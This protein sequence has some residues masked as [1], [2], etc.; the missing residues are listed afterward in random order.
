MTVLPR[1]DGQVS[2]IVSAWRLN[3]ATGLAGAACML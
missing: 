2:G 1:E 3:M